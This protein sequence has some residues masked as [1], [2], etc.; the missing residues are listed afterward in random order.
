M[1]ILSEILQSK[2]IPWSQ[3][4][5][6]ERFI[7]ARSKMRQADMPYGVKLV[8]HKIQSKRVVVKD[9]RVYSNV[10]NI[11]AEW[12][13]EGLQELGKY[14]LICVLDGFIDYQVG[15]YK[16]QCGPGYFIFI[17]PGLPR[18]IKNTYVD[19]QKCTSCNIVTF[20]LHP[21]AVEC[22]MTRRAPQQSGQS[23]Y[24]LIPHECAASLFEALM[25]EVIGGKSKSL[26][27]GEGLLSVFLTLLN[28]E[29]DE[30]NFQHY[31][32]LAHSEIDSF[33]TTS[34]NFLAHLEGYVQTNLRSPLTLDSAAAEM[35]F[36]R[37]QFTRVMRRETGKSFNEFLAERR[38]EEA[39]RLLLNSQWAV[40]TVAS[41]IGF[42]SANYF[43]TFFKHHMGL[44][45]T[46]F[47]TRGSGARAH[48]SVKKHKT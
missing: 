16:L 42:K 38:L 12:P 8:P 33:K 4:N 15:D 17:P 10:R 39:K 34:G 7:V 40:N 11:V 35:Y 26:Q 25:K 23:N 32:S 45:P 31:R 44:T 48:K 29:V 9:K 37:A 18:P 22:W 2:L 27:I 24:Y 28:R 5:A 47:R 14:L 41:L 6:N 1:V 13:E 19:L 3:Q 21:H 30:G 20:L 43:R 46:E 36:S